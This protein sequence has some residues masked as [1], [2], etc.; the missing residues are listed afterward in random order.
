M[1]A[2]Y[3]GQESALAEIQHVL[4]DEGRAFIEHHFRNALAG[5][6]GG[7][8]VTL[9]D[10]ER[11]GIGLDTAMLHLAVSSAWHL[12]EDLRVVV[13]P[14]VEYRGERTGGTQSSGEER[15]DETALKEMED[16][17]LRRVNQRLCL[18]SLTATVGVYG[19]ET[20]R[21]ALAAIQNE[22]EKQVAAD[23]E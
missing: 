2:P 5:I 10:I 11:Q 18:Q 14:P 22:Q 1:G 12:A 23:A 7:I 19:M 17:V 4:S 3:E 6:V 15:M 13:S 20:V 9:L 8:D 16:R 21:V